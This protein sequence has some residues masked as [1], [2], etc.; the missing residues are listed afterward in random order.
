MID[1]INAFSLA[2]HFGVGG[3]NEFEGSRIKAAA[4]YSDNGFDSRA[5][6]TSGKVAQT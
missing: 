3:I 1:K 6:G 2:E 4:T 5:N